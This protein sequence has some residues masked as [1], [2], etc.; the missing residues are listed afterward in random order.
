MT[1]AMMQST[2]VQ[3]NLT[4]NVN[5]NAD[6]ALLLL[7]A[8]VALVAWQV[9]RVKRELSYLASDFIEATRFTNTVFIIG[10]KSLAYGLVGVK[11]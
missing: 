3:F 4:V 11:L 6:R 8:L 1:T 9:A 5:V 2:Q 7:V 10:L